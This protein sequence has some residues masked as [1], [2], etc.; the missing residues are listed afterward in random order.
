MLT[1]AVSEKSVVDFLLSR[2][3]HLE[4]NMKLLP[5]PSLG[6]HAEMIRMPHLQNCQRKS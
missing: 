5:L 4:S 1:L 6:S 2:I 3:R